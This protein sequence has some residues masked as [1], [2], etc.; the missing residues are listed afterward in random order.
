MPR[1]FRLGDVEEPLHLANTEFLVAKDERQD[2]EADIFGERF[3]LG[4]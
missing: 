4:G 3:E 1:G 2:L